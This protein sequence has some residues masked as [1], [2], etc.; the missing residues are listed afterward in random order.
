MIA[1]TCEV[2]TRKRG[3][4][5]LSVEEHQQRKS[6]VL[7]LRQQGLS[8]KEIKGACSFDIGPCIAKLIEEG[9][10]KDGRTVGVWW[11]N[12][13]HER[14]QL[15]IELCKKC[16]TLDEMGIVLGNSIRGER[17]TRERARQLIE[18]ISEAHGTQVFEPTTA[19]ERY[20]KLT[21]AT[22]FIGVSYRGARK[23]CQQKEIPHLFR[24]KAQQY[25]LTLEGVEALCLHPAI[26]KKRVCALDT[27]KKNFIRK[28]GGRNLYCSNECSKQARQNSRI[29]IGQNPPNNSDSLRKWHKPLYQQ[30]QQHTI[31]DDDQWITITKAA[32]YTGLSCIQLW[33]LAYRKIITI[34]YHP[35]KT[36]PTTGKP[37]MLY[38]ISQMEVARQIFQDFKEGK[39]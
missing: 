38:S 36:A 29:A 13:Q 24:G 32:S 3:R 11:R 8:H 33:Y 28:K 21:E 1:T 20:W 2:E 30:L 10:I 23:L 14:T 27:C 35:T 9:T 39:I 25:L 37:V 7:A 31:P 15:V 16:K 18:K 17:L 19:E 12:L 6:E 34:K 4:P 22:K 5:K 26:T